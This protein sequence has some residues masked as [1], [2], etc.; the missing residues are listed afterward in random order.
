MVISCGVFLVACGIVGGSLWGRYGS[1][2]LEGGCVLCRAFVLK[3]VLVGSNCS[4]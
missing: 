3:V 4:L 2:L 1:F